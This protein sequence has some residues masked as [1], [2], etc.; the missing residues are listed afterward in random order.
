MISVSAA[1]YMWKIDIL[2]IVHCVVGILYLDVYVFVFGECKG[3]LIVVF[4]LFLLLS[5]FY[6]GLGLG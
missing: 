4:C 1:G 5:S 2:I 6:S 3:L